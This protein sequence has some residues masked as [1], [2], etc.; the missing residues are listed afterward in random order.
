MTRRSVP[1]R[2]GGM[3]ETTATRAGLVRE[4]QVA[5]QKLRHDA[6]A[7]AGATLGLAALREATPA[8]AAD[9]PALQEAALTVLA[10]ETKLEGT[11]RAYA[12]AVDA[13][14]LLM[15]VQTTPPSP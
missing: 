4:T 15:R 11:A 6:L 9:D 13:L 2:L 7:L 1:H 8:P 10:L 5:R 3:D 14:A 12:F